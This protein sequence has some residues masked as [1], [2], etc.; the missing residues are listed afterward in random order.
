[1]LHTKALTDATVYAIAD[2]LQVS[3]LDLSEN[4]RITDAGLLRL[5]A[6]Q[7]NTLQCLY[8]D[9]TSVTAAGVGTLIRKC[10][11]LFRLSL[12]WNLNQEYFITHVMPYCNN[13]KTL[14]FADQ[15]RLRDPFLLSLAHHC[16]NLENLTLFV[17]DDAEAG[18]RA[19]IKKCTRL[20]KVLLHKKNLLLS[21]AWLLL[22]PGLK[23]PHKIDDL[24]EFQY[25]FKACDS[26]K[27]IML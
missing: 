17:N 1:M 20:R 21:V 18:V 23:F 27:F 22:R 10:S 19:V 7:S 16:P 24:L 9:G 4:P 14:A 8:A 26:A 13:L 2:N 11:K 15:T 5:A 25:K 3:T 12:P 6:T